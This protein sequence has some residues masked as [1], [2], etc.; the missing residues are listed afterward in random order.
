MSS[1]RSGDNPFLMQQLKTTLLNLEL[2]RT[3]LLEKFEPDYRPVQELQAQI[4]ETVDTITKAE[5][6][7]DREENDRPQPIV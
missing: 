4:D 6:S 3:E 2:K 5:K 7:P 1:V